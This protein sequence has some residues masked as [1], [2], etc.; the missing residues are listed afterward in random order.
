M[1]V[2]GGEMNLTRLVEKVYRLVIR[3]ACLPISPIIR[4]FMM[5]VLSWYRPSKADKR[6]CNN[7]TIDQQSEGPL[8]RPVSMFRHGC[9]ERD[10]IMAAVGSWSLQY[11]GPEFGPPWALRVVPNGL[12]SVFLYSSYLAQCSDHYVLLVV[13][14]FKFAPTWMI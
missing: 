2:F 13:F 10:L 12:I 11:E 9:V 4:T 7:T 6:L 5:V 14:D 8:F 3:L 1:S